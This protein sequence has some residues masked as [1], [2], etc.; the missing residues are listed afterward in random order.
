MSAAQNLSYAAVQVV[1]NLGAVATVGGSVVATS[2][3]NYHAR[4]KLAQLV[5]L[6]WLTQAAS[7][8]GFGLV[9][10]YFYRKLPDISGIASYALGVK[11]L[12]ATL[13]IVLLTAYLWRSNHWTAQQQNKAWILASVIAISAISAAAFLRW[14]A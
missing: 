1:H 13:G 9:S 10:Y 5:L 12:C 2:L 6:G 11:M 7:G 4:R 3:R 8:L 14:F